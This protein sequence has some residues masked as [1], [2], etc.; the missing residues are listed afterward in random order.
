MLQA[1]VELVISGQAFPN[2]DISIAGHTIP[3][4]P[5][6]AFSLRVSVPEGMRAVPIEARSRATQKTRRLTLRFGR[7]FE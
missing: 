4:G 1:S 3:V 2:T 5:D 7:Q 6:G